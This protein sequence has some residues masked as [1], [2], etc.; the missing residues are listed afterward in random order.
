[1]KIDNHPVECKAMEL[2]LRGE[3]I[4]G[5]AFQDNFVA[6]LKE[7]IS[8][9]EQHCTCP[10]LSCKYHGNCLVCVAIHR[11]HGNHLPFCLQDMLNKRIHELSQLTEHSVLKTKDS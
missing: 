6:E 2:F 7:A 11:G 10:K 5:E 8:C 3:R 1:M 4:E 9:G